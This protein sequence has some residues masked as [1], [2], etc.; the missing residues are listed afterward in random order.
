MKSHPVST[1]AATLLQPYS[2][3]P[4]GPTTPLPPP[5]P[6]EGRA[7]RPPFPCRGARGRAGGRV[8]AAGRSRGSGAGGGSVLG[9]A[10]PPLAAA[11]WVRA[12]GRCGF[13]RATLKWRRS[14]AA[15]RAAGCLRGA[16][17][18]ASSPPCRLPPLPPPLPPR[19][20]W[21]L[22]TKNPPTF[23]CR[24]CAAASWAKAKLMQPSSFSTQ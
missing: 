15:Q 17:G 6:G 11:L 19:Q 7:R 22:R 23:C 24:T 18:A 4:Y 12:G 21:R 13:R 9:A 20:R 10:G 3:V 2:A 14:R 16:A 8:P 5:K 1:E